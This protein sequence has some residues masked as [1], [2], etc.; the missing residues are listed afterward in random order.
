MALSKSFAREVATKTLTKNL[1][2]TAAVAEVNGNFHVDINLTVT[3]DASATVVKTLFR[4]IIPVVVAEAAGINPATISVDALIYAF[5]GS[6]STY[7]SGGI[8]PPLS[9]GT[10][11]V[12]VIDL[13]A[14]LVASGD[15]PE[16]PT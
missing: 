4:I 10:L 11:G 8:V 12:K 14:F 16:N 2:I 5:A 6:S 7:S 3:T 15:S 1:S 9:Q 13:N